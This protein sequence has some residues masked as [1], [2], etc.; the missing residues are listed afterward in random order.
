M[1]I[2]LNNEYKFMPKETCNS[3]TDSITT[4]HNAVPHA[5]NPHGNAGNMPRQDM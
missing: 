3:A 5:V 4:P 2:G 1:H